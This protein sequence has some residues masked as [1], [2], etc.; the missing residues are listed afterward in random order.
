[1]VAIGTTLTDF[2]T[3]TN[4]LVLTHP[5][6]ATW[7]AII[8]YFAMFA[9]LALVGLLG[10]RGFGRYNGLLLVGHDGE[11]VVRFFF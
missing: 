7:G 4:L 6:A 1:M 3:T 11:R 10:L 8:G 5:G 9:L 2:T